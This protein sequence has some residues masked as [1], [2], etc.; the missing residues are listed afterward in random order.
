MVLVV[1]G[2]H[3]QWPKKANES[4]EKQKGTQGL[5][6]VVSGG[7]AGF[8]E[9]RPKTVKGKPISVFRQPRG[10]TEWAI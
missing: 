5:S 1:A 2:L 6:L 8:H 9:Q 10:T 4:Q 7:E 3:E